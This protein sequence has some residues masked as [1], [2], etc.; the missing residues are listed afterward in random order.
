MNKIRMHMMID[1]VVSTAE[2]AAL[3]AFLTAAAASGET[4]ST[5]IGMIDIHL[6][7]QLI[8]PQCKLAYNESVVDDALYGQRNA[9]EGYCSYGCWSMKHPLD[10]VDK[11]EP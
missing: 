2:L 3:G 8:C 6:R 1:N 10:L 5:K 4:M 7:K 9:Y 11:S